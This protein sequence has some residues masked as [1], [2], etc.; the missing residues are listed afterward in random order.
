MGR[1]GGIGGYGLDGQRDGG[2]GGSGTS[3]HNHGYAGQ[4]GFGPH[5]GEYH[6]KKGARISDQGSQGRDDNG[7]QRGERGSHGGARRNQINPG[8]NSRRM[9]DI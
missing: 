3:D 4:H 9:K 1:K 8:S 6:L 5:G 7:P 2:K